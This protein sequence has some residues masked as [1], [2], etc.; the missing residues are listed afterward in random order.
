MAYCSK[1]S[2][3]LSNFNV[4]EEALEHAFNGNFRTFFIKLPRSLNYPLYRGYYKYGVRLV[5]YRGGPSLG[6]LRGSRKLDNVR[7]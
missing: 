2:F 6:T 1:D 7:S 3:S 5:Q 4:D